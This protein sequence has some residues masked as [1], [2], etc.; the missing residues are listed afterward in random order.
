MREKV[1]TK[2]FNI[3]AIIMFILLFYYSFTLTGVNPHD[4]QSEHIFYQ[5]DSIIKNIIYLLLTCSLLYFVWMIYQKKSLK[6]TIQIIETIV[7]L[8]AALIS[9][10]WVANS[11]TRPVSDQKFVVQSAQ[12]MNEGDFSDFA[13]GYYNTNKHQL[14][15]VTF[16]RILY[17]IF[18]NGNYQA[19]QYF[20]ALLVPALIYFG[21][22]GIKLITDNNEKAELI[23]LLLMICCFPLYAYTPFVYGEI[24]MTTFLM[25]EVWIFLS[26]IK[27]FKWYKVILLMVVA[28]AAVQMKKN[29]LIVLLAFF[30]VLIVKII[31]KFDK[32]YLA[33]FTAVLAGIILSTAVING[34][35]QDKYTENTEAKSALYWIVMGT[36]TDS[37]NVGWYNSYVWGDEITEE[38]VYNDLKEFL[39]EC[40]DDPLYALGLYKEKMTAQWC[41]PMYQCFIMN[42][43]FEEEPSALVDSF[44]HGKLRGIIEPLMNIYQLLIYGGI[45]LMLFIVHKRWSNIENYLL[46][47]GV[48][49]GFLF[50]LIWEAKTRY[51][52]PYY[53]LMIPYAAIGIDLLLK[54]INET[55]SKKVR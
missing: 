27:E 7:I 24:A 21:C 8:A 12:L 32:K 2:I 54:K 10:Y 4:L 36:N 15:I 18:G 39:S 9:I 25:L 5:S 46:L 33:M 51:A 3:L 26:C 41:A 31:Q 37:E 22:R 49:G 6:N 11:N 14:G 30:I 43:V 19:F 34:I 40:A 23:Y 29:A 20:S 17:W 55:I 38:M 52:F 1:L 45:L 50:T 44:Y 47:I 13:D 16:M 42:H 48:F 28:G 35:Y 53:I